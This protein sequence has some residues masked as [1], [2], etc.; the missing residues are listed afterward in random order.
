M[1]LPLTSDPQLFPGQKRI[2]EGWQYW[3]QMIGRLKPG[4]TLENVKAISTGCFSRRRATACR[5]TWRR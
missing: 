4:A 3:L 5:A 1:T 2:S